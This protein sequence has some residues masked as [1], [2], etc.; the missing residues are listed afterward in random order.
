[1]KK[2]ILQKCLDNLLTQG[3]PNFEIVTVNHSSFDMT[4]EIIIHIEQGT[5]KE[6]WLSMQNLNQL[7]GLGKVIGVIPKTITCVYNNLIICFR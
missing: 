6:F 3:Y 1:M 2:I 4:G 5:Q 7:I